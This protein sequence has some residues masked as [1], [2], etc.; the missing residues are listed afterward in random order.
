MLILN[1][2]RPGQIEKALKFFL[3]TTSKVNE[4]LVLSR[5]YFFF[6]VIFF[7]KKKWFLFGATKNPLVMAGCMQKFLEK[8]QKTRNAENT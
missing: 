4:G 2:M 5:K 1:V 6:Y 8:C 7:K 3:S